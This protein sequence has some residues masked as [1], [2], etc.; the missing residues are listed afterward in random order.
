MLET[1]NPVHHTG[2]V[3]SMDCGF[4]VL[5]RITAMH[6]FGVYG[7]SL[8]KKQ[9]YWPKNVPGDAIDSYFANKELGSAKTFRQIFDGKPFLVHFHKDNR[10]VTKL[11][12]THGIINKI[13]T[14]KTL[15]RVAGEWKTFNYTDPISCHNHSKI[16]WMM[17]MP[18]VMILLV[19]RM[20]GI[21]NGSLAVNS[22]SFALSQKSTR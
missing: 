19:W 20:F 22:L 3:V 14:H 2:K 11:M 8:I 9:R 18:E 5:V 16:G 12:S 13:P 6:N 4:F 1:T 10:Y 7:K 15:S 21:P 17:S